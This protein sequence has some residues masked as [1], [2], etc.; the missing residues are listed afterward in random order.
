ME[1]QEL[2]SLC[3]SIYRKHR[4]AIDLIVEFGSSSGSQDALIE[5]VESTFDCEFLQPRGAKSCWYL[6]K[7]IGD[8][9]PSS[10]LRGW[11]FLPR[12][13][14]LCCWAVLRDDGKTKTVV[15]LGP[16]ADSNKRLE[17]VH[18]FQAAGFKFTKTAFGPSAK[19]SRLF[20]ATGSVALDEDGEPDF[21]DESVRSTFSKLFKKQ[22]KS[23]EEITAVLKEFSW[24]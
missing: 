23:I 3:K 18:A 14:A 9:L 19:Y 11:N 12:E 7:L 1:D 2:V 15:E 17:L 10:E 20:S 8:L 22:Q 16:L 5:L 13:V 24:D 6:P 21:S 4:E